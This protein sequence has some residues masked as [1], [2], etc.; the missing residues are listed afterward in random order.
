[1]LAD[2]HGAVESGG[3]GFPFGVR[4]VMKK[5]D[6]APHN[7]V[8]AVCADALFSYTASQMMAPTA[9]I[10]SIDATISVRVRSCMSGTLVPPRGIPKKCKTTRLLF[11]RRLGIDRSHSGGSWPVYGLRSL[12]YQFG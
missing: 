8:R 3:F 12:C 4:R 2:A 5:D 10:A 9:M 7:P 6:A 11:G 1:M